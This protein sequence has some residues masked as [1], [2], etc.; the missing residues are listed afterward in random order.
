MI[1]AVYGFN[2]DLSPFSL[3][4][5]RRSNADTAA[6]DR[7]EVKGMKGMSQFQK[8][9]IRNIHD[10]ID[11]PDIALFEPVSQPFGGSPQSEIFH[12]PSRVSVTEF[13]IENVYVEI[14]FSGLGQNIV[15]RKFKR[16]I[17]H[18]GKLPR[19]TDNA[20]TVGPV[21]SNV[22]FKND[23]VIEIFHGLHFKAYHCEFMSDLRS[24]CGNRDKFSQPF[25]GYTH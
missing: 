4:G 10:I 9:V 8:H 15:I 16:R 18:G 6:F 14:E 22:H 5:V 3:Y 13:L 12:D 25:K 21:G 11:R 17:V 23:V 2:H 7:A 1:D 20:Q 24:V 19:N